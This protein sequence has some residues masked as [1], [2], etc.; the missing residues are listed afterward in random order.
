MCYPFVNNAFLNERASFGQRI[1]IA[2]I[3]ND[4]LWIFNSY[5]NKMYLSSMV[6]SDFPFVIEL[7][8]FQQ[9]LQVPGGMNHYCLRFDNYQA[10]SPAVKIVFIITKKTRSRLKN[11]KNSV[12]RL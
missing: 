2:R 9:I 11:Y 6:L 8:L 10:F 7:I 1:S 12:Y 4:A 5:G 3:F